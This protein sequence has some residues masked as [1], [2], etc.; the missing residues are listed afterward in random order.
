[1]AFC[2]VGEKISQR[3]QHEIILQKTMGHARREGSEKNRVCEEG[4][5]QFSVP[6]KTT[7]DVLVKICEELKCDIGDICAIVPD[8]E[9]D[10][11]V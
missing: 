6:C 5:D 11:K 4:K 8:D 3:S 1:M 2:Q 9:A 7:T 10:D